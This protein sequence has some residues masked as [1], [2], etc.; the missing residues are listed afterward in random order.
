M[1]YIAAIEHFFVHKKNTTKSRSNTHY[2][3]SLDSENIGKI[4]F[5]EAQKA[6]IVAK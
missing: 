1:I 6:R 2:T 4:A 5:T 3:T